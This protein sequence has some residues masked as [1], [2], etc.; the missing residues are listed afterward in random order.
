[1]AQDQTKVIHGPYTVTFSD[2]NVSPT[3]VVFSG[4][5]KDS[6]TFDLASEVAVTDVVD[7][8]AIRDL[9]GRLLTVEIEVSEVIAADLDSI[10]TVMNT[11]DTDDQTVAIQFT[12][13]PTA[14][15][16]ITLAEDASP[17]LLRPLTVFIDM[18]NFRPVMKVFFSG[19]NA[20]TIAQL[21]AI[22]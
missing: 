1:M 11:A 8:S 5:N 16:T 20:T 2:G 13:M 19:S 6:I 22:T 15:D 9:A 10:E 7:G 12:N 18:V 17:A 3:T 21:I 14:T 4:S